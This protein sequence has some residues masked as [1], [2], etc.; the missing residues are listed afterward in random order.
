MMKRVFFLAGLLSATLVSCSTTA[1]AV[2]T[3]SATVVYLSDH[4]Q[5]GEPYRTRMIVTPGFLRM[6]DGEDGRDFIL[7]DRADATIYSVSSGDRQV[8]VMR[9]QK[10]DIEPPVRLIRNV[11]VDTAPFPAVGG[12]KVAHYELMTNRQRCYDLYAA[13]GLLPDVVL[14]LRQYRYALA[15]QQAATLAVTPS[16]FQTPCDMDNNVFL[17]ARHLDYGFPVRLV[18]MTGR[19]T[20]LLDYKTGFRASGDL[21]KLPADYQRRTLNELRNE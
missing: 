18:D 8:L 10:V 14:A 2:P 15:G 6:D 5:G 21:F 20:Q 16:E 19:M 17:P 11:L 1:P 7:F 4:E 9:R 13:D 12:H 3:V